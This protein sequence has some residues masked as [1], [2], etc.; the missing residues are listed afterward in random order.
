MENKEQIRQ[1]LEDIY[2]QILPTL[3]KLEVK[4]LKYVKSEKMV[5]NS[6]YFAF[7]V[8]CISYISL[9][10]TENYKIIFCTV[11]LFLLCVLNVMFWKSQKPK[12]TPNDLKYRM[13]YKLIPL[14]G[15]SIWRDTEYGDEFE[16]IYKDVKFCIIE[17]SYKLKINFNTKR[18]YKVKTIIYEKRNAPASNIKLNE[19]FYLLLLL[20]LGIIVQILALVTY[21]YIDIINDANLWSGILGNNPTIKNFNIIELV[22]RI[23]GLI[24][25]FIFTTIFVC[26]VKRFLFN[27]DF[28]Y[29]VKAEKTLNL[30]SVDFKNKFEVYGDE[31]EGR[32][33]LT[34][35]FMNRLLTMQTAFGSGDLTCIIDGNN[36]SFEIKKTKDL[37]EVADLDKPV[38][39]PECIKE[40]YNEMT[41][42]W[43][44]ID[45]FKL[46]ENTG[47]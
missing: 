30:E 4:R 18:F 35:A 42:I 19:N 3:E 7:G 29:I 8:L 24:L 25:G 39:S 33:A 44:M 15:L 17:T 5:D 34:T 11:I 46:D 31:V 13:M 28:S 36:I 47:L 14:F 1:S 40:F 45:H 26:I 20:I 23:I 10:H 27:A 37:F 38:N 41:S 9:F 32:Y 16:G 2:N 12:F 43:D 6:V 21:L 22:C